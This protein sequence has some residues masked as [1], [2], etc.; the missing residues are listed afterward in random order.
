MYPSNADEIFARVLGP[1]HGQPGGRKNSREGKHGNKSGAAAA[2]ATPAFAPA[3]VASQPIPILQRPFVR[4]H[5]HR[6]AFASAAAATAALS[7]YAVF[8]VLPLTS[9]AAV[10]HLCVVLRADDCAPAA[11]ATP[12]TA[13]ASRTLR[14]R[15]TAPARCRPCPSRSLPSRETR[16]S[17]R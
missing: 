16:R 13:E 9:L 2:A 11:A 8:L 14:P 7:V 17:L 3:L 5:H 10:A 15:A 4:V 1:K 12:R 6:T